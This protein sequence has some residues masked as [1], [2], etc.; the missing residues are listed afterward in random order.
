MIFCGTPGTGKTHLACSIANYLVAEDYSP[1]FISVIKAIRRIKET[2]RRDSVFK[3]QDIFDRFTSFDLLILDE[4][5]VQF[6]TRAEEMIVTEIINER[7]EA[8][9]PTILI[10]NLPVDGLAKYLKPRVME[11]M[12]ENGGIIVAFD[13]KSHRKR[14]V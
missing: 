10:S 8:N 12:E 6:G 1:L 4:I 14:N 13:W 5:G 11:R 9:K 3:E 2:Y 7:Y